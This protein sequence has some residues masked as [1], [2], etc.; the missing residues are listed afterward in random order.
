MFGLF[1]KYKEQKRGHIKTM[2]LVLQNIDTLSRN[3]KAVQELQFEGLRLRGH[4][5]PCYTNLFVLLELMALN[6][7]I[8]LHKESMYEVIY[9]GIIKLF[10][11]TVGHNLY[12]FKVIKNELHFKIRTVSKKGKTIM[13]NGSTLKGSKVYQWSVNT[14]ED[15]RSIEDYKKFIDAEIYKMMTNQEY[16]LISSGQL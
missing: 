13:S 16:I 4:I 2:M 6:G 8:Y 10:D 5:V 11:T 12:T 1:K 9:V 7:S 3:E 14:F 15:D